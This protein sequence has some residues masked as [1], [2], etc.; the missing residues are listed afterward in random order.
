MNI[1]TNPINSPF[2]MRA[3][4]YDYRR[5]KSSN[6]RMCM[7]FH[8]HSYCC[9]D[10][11]VLVLYVH[12]L[13]YL[14]TKKTCYFWASNVGTNGFKSTSKDYA[15]MTYFLPK[16][17]NCH[18]LRIRTVDCQC[19]IHWVTRQFNWYRSPCTLCTRWCGKFLLLLL[20]YCR[21]TFT[22]G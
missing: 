20:L 5:T 14:T 13:F 2:A 8:F 12:D 1:R 6:M 16:G 21:Y 3:K 18:C 4:M 9:T 10:Q 7:R 11:S 19:L 17:T 15:M 22:S